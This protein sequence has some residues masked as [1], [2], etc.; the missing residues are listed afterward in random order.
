M[1]N[2]SLNDCPFTDVHKAIDEKRRA[3]S[4]RN[5][6]YMGAGNE[7]S[8]APVLDKNAS[9]PAQCVSVFGSPSEIPDASDYLSSVFSHSAT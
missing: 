6:Y 1:N 4:C 9:A 8:L 7:A 2:D 5:C 3:V